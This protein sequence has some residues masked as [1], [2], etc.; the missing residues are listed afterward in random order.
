MPAAGYSRAFALVLSPSK[1]GLQ[2]KPWFGG[3][4]TG[5]ALVGLVNHDAD[6]PAAR[7]WPPQGRAGQAD[8]AL[9]TSLCAEP[10]NAQI[11]D[12]SRWRAATRTVLTMHLGVSSPQ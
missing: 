6:D 1:D 4:T 12:G 10:A 11:S 8:A 5:L 9:I 7:G 3:L 2:P